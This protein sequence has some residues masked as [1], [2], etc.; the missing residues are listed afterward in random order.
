MNKHIKYII[1]NN[2]Q[3]FNPAV[4]SDNDSPKK[5]MPQKD[6]NQALYIETPTTH[7]RLHSLIYELLNQGITD[8]NCI[9]TSEITDFSFLF[10]NRTPHIEEIDISRWNVSNGK[11]FL[12][13]CK[14]ADKFNCDLSQWDVSNAENMQG[15]FQGCKSFTSD[16]SQWDVRKCTT[17][18]NMF[19]LCE[20][21]ESDLSQWKVDACENFAFMFCGATKFNSDLSNWHVDNGGIFKSMFNGCYYFNSDLSNWHVD[22]A[23]DLSHMFSMCYDFNSDLKDWHVD[24]CQNFDYMF[25]K[26]NHFNSDI[27]SWNVSEGTSFKHMFED[28]FIFNQ[29]L[30]KWNVTISATDLS[31]MFKNC[32]TLT[33]DLS[34]FK[35]GTYHL[36]QMDNMFDGCDNLIRLGKIPTW[37]KQSVGYKYNN[38]KNNRSNYYK[39]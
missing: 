37:Y 23:S 19:Y 3:G 9:D 11:T 8:L 38:T 22:R 27:S 36:F 34:G 7:L 21:F 31:S 20:S 35:Q 12:H 32:K 2:Y 26:C 10:S 25:Y 17:F 13:M 4:I 29:D 39:R 28:C 14:N 24:I 15:M 5:K 16:L 6:I 1:E 30:S 33:C 18:N